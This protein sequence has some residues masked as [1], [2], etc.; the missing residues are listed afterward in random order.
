M[1]KVLVALVLGMVV[2]LSPAS[3]I[4]ADINGRIA[5]IVGSGDIKPGAKVETYLTTKE[6]ILIP[7]TQRRNMGINESRDYEWHK[8]VLH[9]LDD[10]WRKFDGAI[11]NPEYIKSKTKTNLEGRFKFSN[12]EAGK[13]FV[14]VTWPSIVARHRVFWQ[15]P[16]DVESKDVDVELSN[17]NFTV[18]PYLD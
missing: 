4:A 1:K 14:V 10:A 3:I 15:V 9:A 17:D 16:V 2:S 11:S 8:A 5:V 13:Y 12:I 18:P 6:L 7:M